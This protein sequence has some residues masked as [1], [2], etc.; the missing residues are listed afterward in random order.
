MQTNKKNT[1]EKSIIYLQYNYLL[2][3]HV[4]VHEAIHHTEHNIYFNNQHVCY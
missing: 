3:V 4:F 2:S 1:F